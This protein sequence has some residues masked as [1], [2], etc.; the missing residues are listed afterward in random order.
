MDGSGF[1]TQAKLDLIV[2]LGAHPLQSERTADEVDLG[3]GD[4]EHHLARA[5]PRIVD[6]S[7]TALLLAKTSM[8]FEIFALKSLDE[9]LCQFRNGMT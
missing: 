5:D 3:A 7:S 4:F 6:T 9:Q 1:E 8:Q 2:D